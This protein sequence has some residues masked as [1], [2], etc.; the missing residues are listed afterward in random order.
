MC[1]SEYINSMINNVQLIQYYFVTTILFIMHF[2]QYTIAKSKIILIQVDKKLVQNT[3]F[4]LNK[5][6]ITTLC[7]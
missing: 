3:S 1:F 7:N 6:E 4:S 2:F 5:L